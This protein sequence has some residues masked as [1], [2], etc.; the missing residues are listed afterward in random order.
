[1]VAQA[2]KFWDLWSPGWRPRWPVVG[3]SPGAMQSSGVGDR[4]GEGAIGRVPEAPSRV[5]RSWTFLLKQREL[6]PPSSAPLF[7]SGLRTG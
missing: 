7:Y 2:A 4:G 3:F 1:M 6:I 5:R